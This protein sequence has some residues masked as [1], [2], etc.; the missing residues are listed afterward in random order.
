MQIGRTMLALVGS[1]TATMQ[2]YS[3]VGKSSDCYN[4]YVW[5][6]GYLADWLAFGEMHIQQDSSFAQVNLRGWH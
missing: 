5:I 3:E 6:C 4:R 1:A 2:I